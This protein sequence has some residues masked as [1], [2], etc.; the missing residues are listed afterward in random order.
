MSANPITSTLAALLESA[1]STALNLDPAA[2]DQIA[3]L[4][5][6]VLLLE[7]TVVPGSA[8]NPDGTRAALRVHCSDANGGTLSIM[9]DSA[10]NVRAPNAI[11][12]GTVANF[13]QA[14]VPGGDHSL[15]EGI[16]IEGDER[17]L[18]ALQDCFRHIQPDWRAPLEAFTDTLSQRFGA[19]PNRPGSPPLFQD[20][21]G[22][23]EFA[24]ATIRTAV[25]DA[26]ASSKETATD[27]SAKFWAQDDDVEA[28]A[29][30]LENL[31]MNVDR[32]RAELEHS[33]ASNAI[34]GSNQT[35][36]H[37]DAK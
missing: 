19:N 25:T 29:R 35:T 32:L 30:R 2:R 10:H 23:A 26:L 12:R 36:T 7:L 21:L 5:D 33:K 14:L 15:P 37:P 13:I 4:N 8:T 22:Q 1:A 11:V 9:A 28:F 6:Q 31:Q 27:A 34:D 20:L 16:D 3:A 18:M 17:L 24:F